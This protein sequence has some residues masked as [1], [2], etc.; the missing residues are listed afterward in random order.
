MARAE[1][2]AGRHHAA[3]RQAAALGPREA[4]SRRLDQVRIVRD[5]PQEPRP[6]PR[7]RPPAQPGR[8]SQHDPRAC[9]GSTTT[10]RPNFRP[11]TRGTDLTI[12]A[13]SSP[14][15]RCCWKSI[16]DGGQGGCVGGRADEFENRR[17]TDDRRTAVPRQGH[18]A[19]RRDR[20]RALRCRITSRRQFR[21]RFASS[22]PAATSLSWI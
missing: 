3:S 22:M 4:S 7:D 9:W 11:T 17:R 15:R 20:R 19:D 5:R 8:V 21:A 10:P 6:W 14:C 2:R 1:K 12:S 13:R 18:P 16:I